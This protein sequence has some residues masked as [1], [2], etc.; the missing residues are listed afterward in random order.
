MNGKKCRQIEFLQSEKNMLTF[1]ITRITYVYTY[2]LYR[3]IFSFIFMTTYCLV[4]ETL[5]FK[6]IIKLNMH[7]RIIRFKFHSKLNLYI[8]EYGNFFTFLGDER[9]Y[10]VPT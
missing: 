5:W 6:K 9:H 8:N 4:F 3:R 10:I 2:T 1:Y 7:K